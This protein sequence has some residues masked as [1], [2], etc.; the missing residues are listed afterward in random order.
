LAVGDPLFRAGDVEPGFEQELLRAWWGE[1]ARVEPMVVAP[2]A[3]TLARAPGSVQAGLRALSRSRFFAGLALRAL[4]FDLKQVRWYLTDASMR[5]KVRARLIDLISTD[6][7]VVVAHS[8]GSVVAYEALCGLPEH[9]VRTLVTVGSPLGIRNLIFDRLQPAAQDGVGVW[10]GRDRMGWTNVAD[11]GDVV[12]LV[13]DL[14]PSFG[15]RVSC[16]L[17][18]NGVHAHD[19]RPY[20]TDRLTGAAVAAG[21]TS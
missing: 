3:D 12:A 7:R 10:P 5:A 2:D 16:H 9:R 15:Q 4:V 18:H 20:L 8:L 11:A 21:V 14:R 19:A 6:T 13:K 17:V 1:A